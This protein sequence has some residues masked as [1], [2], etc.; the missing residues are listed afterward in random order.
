MRPTLTEYYLGVAKAVS[1]RGE[2]SRRLVGA[3]IVQNNTIVSTGYNGAPAGEPSCLD[4]ACPRASSDA[5]PGTGYAS[6][7]CPVIHAEANA[8]IR[9]GRERCVGATIYVTAEPCD[10]CAPLIRAAGIA[11]V[12]HL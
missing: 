8:I 7:G 1:A 10:L 5:V 11:E 2:C 9:A 4:G 3:V 12:I 6:S